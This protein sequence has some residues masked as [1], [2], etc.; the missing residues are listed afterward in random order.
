MVFARLRYWLLLLL[1]LAIFALVAWFVRGTLIAAWEQLGRHPLRL[2]PLWLLG[3]GG[4]Y[5]LGLAPAALF[6]YYALR[7]MGQKPGI[8]D[9]LRAY[10]VGHLGKYV[11]G[12]ALVVI[13][14]VGMVGGEKVH[15]GVAAASVFVETLTMMA[16]GAFIAALIVAMAL[17]EEVMLFWGA[18]GL[19]LLAVLPTLPPVFRPIAKAA[20]G[21]NDPAVAARLRNLRYRTLAVGWLC[22]APVW[23][24]VGVSLWCVL[25]AMG[26]ERFSPWDD[27]PTLTAT[28]ALATVAGFLSLIPGG[29]GVRDLLLIHLLAHPGLFALGQVEAAV[30]GALLRIVWVLSET[31]ISAILYGTAFLYGIAVAARRAR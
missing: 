10:Y 23:A 26:I 17:G 21:R 31:L 4:V 18:V 19:M 9:T 11:P 6:W 13:I 15:M 8:W 25:R 28:A 3:A 2:E 29:L 1:K 16:V 30:G 27:L 7:V 12:K 22:M 24:A 20:V 5:L 14:R